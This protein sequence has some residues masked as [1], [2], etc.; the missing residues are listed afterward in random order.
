MVKVL[1]FFFH[2]FWLNSLV[3]SLWPPQNFKGTS[4]AASRAIEHTVKETPQTNEKTAMKLATCP[5][6]VLSSAVK[7]LGFS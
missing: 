4:G 6:L 7:L 5:A 2:F 3:L 1:G